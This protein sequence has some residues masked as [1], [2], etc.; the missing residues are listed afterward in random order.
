M[1]LRT[2][3][4][5]AFNIRSGEELPIFLL[6]SYS[7]LAGI[8]LAYIIS[9]GNASFLVVFGT[10]HLPKGYIATGVVGYLVGSV[11]SVLQRRL[12]FA[13]LIVVCLGSL[14][15]TTC[16]FWFGYRLPPD[17]MFYGLAIEQW[18][19]LGL[20]VGIGPFIMLVY[21][22]FRSVSGRLFDL[23]QGKRLFGLISTG[24]VMSSMIGFFSVPIL[25]RVL[26]N[27]T[28]LLV[29]AAV[30]LSLCL[31]VLLIIRRRFLH[32][33]SDP[34]PAQKQDDNTGVWSMLFGSRYFLLL[35]LLASAT[36]FGFYYIDFVFLGQLRTR[37]PDQKL[38]AQF[39]G[40]FYGAIR[41]V[42]FV[43]KTFVS[44]RLINQYG[45]RFGLVVL[46]TLVCAC[47][48]LA[49][50]LEFAG[51]SSLVFL[52]LALD[53]LIERVVTKSLYDPAFNVLYQPIGALMRLSV[54]TRVEGIVQP[55]TVVIAGS[56][57]FLFAQIGSFQL[58]LNVVVVVFVGWLLVAVL[59]NRAYRES[60][61]QHLEQ[62]SRADHKPGQDEVSLL[63]LQNHLK[64]SNP[65]RVLLAQTLLE[66]IGKTAP[67][68]AHAEIQQDWA[69]T[70]LCL[71]RLARVLG[72][73]EISGD[74]IGQLNT[75]DRLM[76]HQILAALRL[77]GFVAREGQVSLV[78]QEIDATIAVSAWCMATLVDLE[79]ADLVLLKSA[80]GREIDEN[81]ERLFKLLSL[82]YDARHIEMVCE[83]FK[84]S[85][86]DGK[87]YG[88]ELIDVFVDQEIKN[89]LF[90]IL[91]D[92]ALGQ[93][94]KR[95][96][97]KFPQQKLSPFDRLKDIV[98]RPY[99]SI[100]EWTRACALDGFVYVKGNQLPYELV[101]TLFHNNPL[102][103]QTAA[104]SMM[105]LAPDGHHLERLPKKQQEEL[106]RALQSSEKP[107]L[108]FEQV[109][110]LKQIAAFSS[111]PETIL[112]ELVLHFQPCTFASGDVV[113]AETDCQ[114]VVIIKG[115]VVLQEG[116]GVMVN[117]DAGRL[118]C[119]WMLFGGDLVA[120]A[121]TPVRAWVM[122]E[123]AFVDL[124]ADYV[125]LTRGVMHG[126]KIVHSDANLSIVTDRSS[127]HPM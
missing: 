117:E 67:V 10:D 49:S 80:I 44:G 115:R 107:A 2:S 106:K 30:S 91:D 40:I 85:S 58:V 69:Q 105:R 103:R 114:I 46:P 33:L 19:A 45:L 66:Q 20:F 59:M 25:L 31:W 35:L 15:V 92:L 84:N 24:D 43:L 76:R 90:P 21:F 11:L 94:L 48:A 9:L 50:G 116:S 57:L 13:N 51:V 88:L 108:I 53:K 34:L 89:G 63:L 18:L 37:F 72:S 93:R 104:W 3:V 41:V 64:D 16:L 28:D 38:L 78:R 82:I 26:P 127:I 55:L 123:A 122:S 39:I 81:R 70:P 61:L 124:L 125:E 98:N 83:S 119:R 121:E 113:F 101:A 118:L 126:A 102:L 120:I 75:S 77:Q 36:V 29:I 22:V 65:E 54:Q 111:V 86:S 60:L 17:M 79:N 12:A 4:V 23:R 68:V 6:G 74:L 5:E 1:S 73:P 56:S 27:P 7:F 71:P 14:L 32:K 42:E 97:E 95:L 52:M 109:L 96:E 8:C 62:R 100:E 47:T 112:A 87:V 110:F 99:G